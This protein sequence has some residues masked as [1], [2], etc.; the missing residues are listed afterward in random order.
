MLPRGQRGDRGG[1]RQRETDTPE[2]RRLATAKSALL[3]IA[4][5]D[6]QGPAPVREGLKQATQI[7]SG[8]DV[9]VNDVRA[10]IEFTTKANLAETFRM[11]IYNP[12]IPPAFRARYAQPAGNQN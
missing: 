9:T 7:L 11:W 3:F 4:L 2:Q 1:R 10:A 6:A 5:E 12:G 8:K